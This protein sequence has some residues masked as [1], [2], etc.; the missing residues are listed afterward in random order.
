VAASAP[1][2]TG[3]SLPGKVLAVFAARRSARGRRPSV[4]AAAAAKAREHVVTVAALASA[5]FGAFQV[6][7]PWFG[8]APG[9]CAV[10]VSLFALDFAV[11]G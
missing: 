6:H 1:S 5:D 8:S 3:V 10:A 7:V 4:L 11:R 2:V 9:W